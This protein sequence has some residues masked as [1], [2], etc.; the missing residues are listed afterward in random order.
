MRRKL[1][2]DEIALW[3][4][5]TEKAEKLHPNASPLPVPDAAPVTAQIKKKPKAVK[6]STASAPSPVPKQSQPALDTRALKRIK[7]GKSK[8][9]ARLDLHGMTLDRAHPALTRFVL[10]SQASGRR[11][12]LVITGKGRRTQDDPFEMA[13]YARGVLN[14]QV[15]QWLAQPP[16]SA[17][18]W[19]VSPAH[20]SYG[21]D[22]AY[23][24]F[25]R[26]LKGR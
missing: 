15:P 20:Q 23:Y 13:P 3:Q 22:G 14:R 9:E 10:S 25:L 11:L 1:S 18:V 21:G 17:V 2:A 19:Q 24:V 6:T 12:V 26:K 8:P 5:V 16:L 4:K 7:K